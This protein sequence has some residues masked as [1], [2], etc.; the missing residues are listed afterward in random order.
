MI[1]TVSN[2][3]PETTQRLV[4]IV[5]ASITSEARAGSPRSEWFGAAGGEPADEPRRFPEEA[6]FL[7]ENGRKSWW[8]VALPGTRTKAF[9]KVYRP[10]PMP[11][12]LKELLRRAPG[13][14]LWDA[15]GRV[16]AAG[17]RTPRRLAAGARRERGALAWTFFA[18]E[19]A[20]DARSL[21]PLVSDARSWDAARRA[22]FARALGLA[23]GRLRARRFV[24]PDLQPANFL[25]RGDPH[26]SFELL[27]VDLRRA[28]VGGPLAAWLDRKTVPQLRRRVL[29]GWDADDI[30]GFFA[31][32]REAS[33]RREER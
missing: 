15:T 25:V 11:W 22:R 4:E 7:R 14:E 18:C 20:S 30:A 3:T 1:R 5:D 24:Q 19:D 23:F 29:E 12:G 21:S 10:R 2:L 28:V 26:G 13:F 17:I 9:V 32:F 27:P 31:A 16:E 6:T 33:A 8:R